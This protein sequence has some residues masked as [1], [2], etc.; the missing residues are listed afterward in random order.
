MI[1]EFMQQILQS[2][3]IYILSSYVAAALV[4]VIMALSSW[5]SK[6]KDENDLRILEKQLNNLSEKQN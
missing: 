4:L 3:D 5:R 2:N 1:E 6:K